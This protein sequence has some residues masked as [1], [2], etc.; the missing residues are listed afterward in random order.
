MSPLI[1]VLAVTALA[2]MGGTGLGG[3]LAALFSRSA[4]EKVTSFLLSFA[5][6]VMTAL[7]CLDLLPEALAAGGLFTAAGAVVLGCGVTAGLEGLLEQSA[8]AKGRPGLFLSGL[9]MAAAIAIHN[10]PEGMVIGASYALDAHTAASAGLTMA[11]VIGLHNIPEGMAVAAPLAGGGVSR[12]RAVLVTVL[13]GAP[14]VLGAA[15]GYS[16]GVMGPRALALS[17]GFASGAMLYVVFAQLLPESTQLWCSRAPAWA[18]M[19]GLL[20][21]LLI[22]YA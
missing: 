20:A 19:T 18:V 12:A 7:V 16:I 8:A 22:L 5:A 21:G 9:I 2:G 6:G 3:L 17:L 1:F 14:T 13:A 11:V 4:S 15:A 10:V